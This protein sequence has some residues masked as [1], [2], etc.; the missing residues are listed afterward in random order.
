MR[1]TGGLPDGL[2]N[3]PEQEKL[4]LTLFGAFSPRATSSEKINSNESTATAR[5]R[6]SFIS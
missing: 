5:S 6:Q 1:Y 4:K 2:L 3:L